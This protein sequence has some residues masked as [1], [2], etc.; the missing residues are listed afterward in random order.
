LTFLDRLH[1]QLQEAEPN[2]AL[3]DELIRLYWLRRQRKGRV[4][5]PTERDSRPACLV[6]KVVCQRLDARWG[7]S[8]HRVARAIG[9]TTR[10]S[11]V[12]ECMNSVIRMHQARHRTLSQP[13]LDLKRLYWNCRSFREGKRRHACPY[14]HLGLRLPT[15]D[16]WMLLQT[17]ADDLTQELSTQQ[18]AV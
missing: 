15:Y 17:A 7:E 11:S 1:R 3:R 2:A 14:Q 18:V 12:V 10:A 9:N 16:A 4:E 5:P 8:Y 13:L 6:Q